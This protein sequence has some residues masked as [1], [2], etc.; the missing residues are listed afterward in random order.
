MTPLSTF[1]LFRRCQYLGASR[2]ALLILIWGMLAALA[3]FV[4]WRDAVDPHGMVIEGIRF[5][6][7]YKS[8]LGPLSLL[9]LCVLVFAMIL[10]ANGL[11][12]KVAGLPAVLA[13]HWRKAGWIFAGAGI[14]GAFM[15]VWVLR[16]FPYSGDEY[17]YLFQAKTYLAG[18]LWNPMP[19]LPDFFR[20]VH[21]SF[22]D[23]KWVSTYPP[24]WPLLLA[25]VSAMRLPFWLACPAAGALLLFALFKLG[26]RRDGPLG[27]VLALAL[28]ALSPFFWF[29]AGSYFNHV[30][31]AAAGLF[32]CWA[33]LD[34]L[35]QARLSKA[36]LTGIALG[37]L[38]L[39][40]P[41]DVPFFA[42]PFAAEFCW[43]ARRQHYLNAPAIVLVGL[44]FLA[45]LLLYNHTIT[46]SSFLGVSSDQRPSEFGFHLVNEEGDV[47]TLRDQLRI[48]A[49]RIVLA[50][51]WTSP[52]L[53]LGYGAAA[54]WLAVCRRL[55]F[56]DLIFP[57]YVIGYLFVPFT[58]TSQYGPRY[59]FEAWPLFVLTVVS[60]LMPLLQATRQRWRAFAS[61]LLMAHLAITLAAGVIFG[62]FMR[63]I[64]DESMDL[65]DQA[66]AE[67]LSNAVIV[68][69]S[70]TSPSRFY[71][72][73]GL[74]RNGISIDGEVIYALDLT[75]RLGEL[76]Q[77][78]PQRLFYIYERAS[79]SPKGVLRRLR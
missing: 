5:W 75:E 15:V 27:G 18:R 28:V 32:F 65:Y 6:L 56:L 31:A 74:V 16:A 64:I 55:S 73:R 52:I 20:L 17:D 54:V 78:F 23:G 4:L 25:G 33:A 47:L 37:V 51:E 76:R 1:R 68:V 3:G 61:S 34:F 7:S 43:K 70:G 50:A 39:I 53:V 62:I 67:G 42:L 77:F 24:G 63:K 12:E 35:D 72:P 36:C 38:G 19:P 48:A 66:A 45:A 49:F 14:V 46:G 26:Q 2:L 30:P 9:V 29:N 10:Q 59:Y 40:R 13:T 57:T 58:G 71:S 22:L 8:R 41:V 11:R 69:H 79:D 44:P 60:G 21:I